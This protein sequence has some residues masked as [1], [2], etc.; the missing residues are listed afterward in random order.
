MTTA[1]RPIASQAIRRLLCAA[2]AA[3]W[4]AMPA[5]G[6]VSVQLEE[7]VTVHLTPSPTGQGPEISLACAAP[8][9]LDPAVFLAAIVERPED[10][11]AYAGAGNVA[12]PFDRVN[13]LYRRRAVAALF[14]ND[15]VDGGG[16]RH[17]V[18]YSG[19]DVGETLWSLSV[20][21]TGNGLNWHVIR[22]ANGLKR[23]ALAK[24]DRLVIPASILRDEM[25]AGVAVPPPTAA[26]VQT[27]QAPAPEPAP[28]PAAMEPE[29]AADGAAAAADLI[30]EELERA[31][32]LVPTEDLLPVGERP[33][34]N[35]DDEPRFFDGG[36]LEYGN[37]GGGE[38]ATYRIKQ[39]EAI[40]SDV[41]IRFT[42]FTGHV[43][44]MYAVGKIVER[45]AIADVANLKPGAEIRIPV[46]ML[47]DRYKP[48]TN[49]AR[50]QFEQSIDETARLR[51]EMRRGAGSRD[52]EGVT[53]ILDSGHGSKDVGK[54]YAKGG[55]YED[56]IAYDIVCRIKL[57]LET[58]TQAKVYMTLYDPSEGYAPRNISKFAADT[59]EVI[60][61]TPN[62]PPSPMDHK[63]SNGAILNL[64]YYLANDIYDREVASGTDPRNVIFSSIHVDSLHPNLRGTM[65]YIP[66]AEHRA[67]SPKSDHGTAPYNQIAEVKAVSSTSAERHRDE[68]LSRAFAET[69]YDELG[70]K[71]VRRHL[72]GPAIR[73][74]IRQTGGKAYVPAV[75][76][77]NK[78]PTKILVETAN[79][80]NSTDRERLAD[81]AWRQ[82][83]AEAYVDALRKHYGDS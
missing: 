43:D 71:Q 12:I 14:P 35:G 7:G 21:L 39:G 16:W 45:S 42:D 54:I 64:R 18:V 82:A 62:Y 28:A 60:L 27:A 79:M 70:V 22:E 68:A 83:V 29:P 38:F 73:N 6:A 13:A 15:T 57:L 80:A 2:A 26:P 81:P 67:R 58:E 47:S 30:D 10:V 46:E 78:V 40:Y 4:L 48:M 41:V 11:A 32:P 61:T 5:S 77:W 17:T 20:W 53:V 72:T 23:P 9:D 25:R 56:E 33:A 37:D 66:G 75:I 51:S 50:Q 8:A 31:M 59:D 36:E 24:G 63:T 1:A 76:R 55:L 3:V 69:L 65:I 52:L 19:S 49:L 44:V 34:A 74:V